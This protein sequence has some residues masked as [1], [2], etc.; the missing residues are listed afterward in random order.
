MVQ[1]E[2]D[3]IVRPTP[4][5]PPSER[6]RLV[7]AGKCGR[8]V[9]SHTEAG[10][11]PWNDTRTTLLTKPG[12]GP[13]SWFRTASPSEQIHKR[14]LLWNFHCRAMGREHR[15]WS[16]RLIQLGPP[17]PYHFLFCKAQGRSSRLSGGG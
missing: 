9:V 8:L 16:D 12:L 6:L 3:L 14:S 17:R 5:F 11:G 1:L 13:V 15:K 10:V 4:H 2:L 7:Y